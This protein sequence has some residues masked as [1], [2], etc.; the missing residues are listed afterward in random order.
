MNFVWNYIVVRICFFPESV[1]VVCGFTWCHPGF[2]RSSVVITCY[3]LLPAVELSWHTLWHVLSVS[4]DVHSPGVM[5]GFGLLRQWHD[6][7]D[8]IRWLGPR[9]QP[10]NIHS[11]VSQSGQADCKLFST[12]LI[13]NDAFESRKTSYYGLG[14]AG[15]GCWSRLLTVKDSEEVVHSIVDSF[16]SFNYFRFPTF[17]QK[18]VSVSTQWSHCNTKTIGIHTLVSFNLQCDIFPSWGAFL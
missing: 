16:V 18:E 5:F 3:Q 8:F 9:T 4:S 13:T 12:T 6:L 7:L 2:Q 10:M 14:I 1:Y 15:W 11:R 17:K